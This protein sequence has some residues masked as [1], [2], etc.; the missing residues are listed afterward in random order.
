MDYGTTVITEAQTTAGIAALGIVLILFAV[1]MLIVNIFFAWSCYKTMKRIPEDSRTLPAWL[2]WLFIVP[3]VGYIFMWMMMPFAIPNS[4]KAV[5]AVRENILSSI[6][7]LFGLGLAYV[8]LGLIA[9][10]PGVNL[11]V[12]IAMLILLIIYWVKVVDVRKAL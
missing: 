2:C 10:I 7:A 8:I 4:L 3:F 1:G 5:A 12:F 11:L 9:W 6:R